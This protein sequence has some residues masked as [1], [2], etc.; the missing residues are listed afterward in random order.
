[1]DPVHSKHKC[2]EYRMQGLVGQSTGFLCL[3]QLT[4]ISARN[5]RNYG[6]NSALAPAS[7]E[8]AENLDRQP[9][10]AGKRGPT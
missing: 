1:M 5:A 2:V 8:L 4:H 10:F 6:R 7:F 3:H 9:T